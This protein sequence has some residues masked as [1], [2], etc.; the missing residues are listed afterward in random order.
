MKKM[1]MCFPAEKTF[2]DGFA[3]YVLD[4]KARNLRDGTR[5][6]TITCANWK[7]CLSILFQF[8]QVIV[9]YR[10]IILDGTNRLKVQGFLKTDIETKQAVHG[11]L[12]IRERLAKS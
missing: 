6:A 3:E 10:S 4:M 12:S 8:A 9:H 1:R 5:Y 2:A 11:W 7:P